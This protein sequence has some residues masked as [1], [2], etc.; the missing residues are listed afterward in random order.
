MMSIDETET[1]NEIRV[2]SAWKFDQRTVDG[3]YPESSLTDNV[4]LKLMPLL[5]VQGSTL[6][7]LA[8]A[9]SSNL[10]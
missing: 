7:F 5:P 4:K 10:K 9:V 6:I 1:E 2:V 8:F 3:I